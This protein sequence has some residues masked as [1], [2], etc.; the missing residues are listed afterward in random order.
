ML[1][2]DVGCC[3]G[4]ELTAPFIGGGRKD[5]SQGASRKS[6]TNWRNNQTTKPAPSKETVGESQ[7][8]TLR[9]WIK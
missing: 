3:R 9:S 4:K 1:A 7:L 6:H 2:V 8:L 5:S